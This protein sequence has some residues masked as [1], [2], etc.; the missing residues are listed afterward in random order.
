MAGNKLDY[1]DLPDLITITEFDG[2]FEAYLEAVYQIFKAE[3]LD[4]RPIF[5]GR[6]L[7]LKD[8][9]FVDGKEATFWHMTTTGE[10]EAERKPDLKR[11]ERIRWSPKMINESEHPYLKV[12]SNSRPGGQESV[13]IWHDAE[14]FLVVLRDRGTYLLPWTA[15]PVQYRNMEKKLLKEYE[16]YLASQKAETAQP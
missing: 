13:L 16:A 14:K 11:M 3:Y 15:Y 5:R 12:W 1:F 9:P 10:I 2:N 4:N 6:Q 7:G 8:T